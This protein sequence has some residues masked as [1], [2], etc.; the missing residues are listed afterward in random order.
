M[1]IYLLFPIPIS[2][3]TQSHSLNKMKEESKLFKLFFYFKL[4]ENKIFHSNKILKR[5]F[6]YFLK[7]KIHSIHENNSIQSNSLTIRNQKG[8]ETKKI[9]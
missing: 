8:N 4:E 2:F 3:L 1:F 6:L 7:R 9:Q 5:K